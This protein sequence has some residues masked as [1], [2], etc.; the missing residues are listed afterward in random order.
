MYFTVCVP[1]L[2]EVGR[3]KRAF[4][5]ATPGLQGWGTSVVLPFVQRLGVPEHA[6]GVSLI[7]FRIGCTVEDKPSRVGTADWLGY[8]NLPSLVLKARHLGGSAF[9]AV[10][11]G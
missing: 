4:Q 11:T 6:I 1:V 9:C 8:T 5:P 2:L 3:D 7:T 10:F